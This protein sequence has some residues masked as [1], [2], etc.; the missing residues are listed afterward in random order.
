VR[1]WCRPHLAAKGLADRGI[2]TTSPGIAG[3]FNGEMKQCGRILLA[4]DG[5]YGRTFSS[6]KAQILNLDWKH[7]LEIK[8]GWRSPACRRKASI[9]GG[10]GLWWRL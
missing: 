8:D 5:E 7:R 3:D 1:L 9:A 10:G 2:E 6:S 4:K